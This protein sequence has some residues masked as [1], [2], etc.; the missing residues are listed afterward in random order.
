MGIE[1]SKYNFADGYHSKTVALWTSGWIGNRMRKG[2]EVWND[3]VCIETKLDTFFS[4]LTLGLGFLIRILL[5]EL[6]TM[7]KSDK[8]PWII[9]ILEGF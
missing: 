4:N 1:K 7:R 9:N 5:E 8:E 6:Q 3:M 2:V